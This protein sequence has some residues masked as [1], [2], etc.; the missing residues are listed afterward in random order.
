[1][2]EITLSGS[3]GVNIYPFVYY[4]ILPSGLIIIMNLGYYIVHVQGRPVVD[5]I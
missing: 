2:V 3:N 5:V 4:W 1:M